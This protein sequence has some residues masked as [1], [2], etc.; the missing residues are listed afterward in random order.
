MQFD[1]VVFAGGGN[2]CWWQAGFWHALNEEYHQKPHLITAVSAGAATACLLYTRPGVDGARWALQYYEKVLKDIHKNAYWENLFTTKPVFPHCDIYKGVLEQVIA[3][4]LELLQSAP[5]IKIGVSVAPS[6][7]GARSSVAIGLLAYQLEKRF[8]KTLHPR[9]GQ[10]I[11]FTRNFYNTHDCNTANNLVDVILQSSCTPP[12]TPVM[13][14]QGQVVLDGGLVDN[15][16]IDGL[17]FAHGGRILV[18]LTRRY[19]YPDVFKRIYKNCELIYVQP[20]RPVAISS[21]DYSRQELMPITYQ[22]G[23]TDFKTYLSSD[24]FQN[25]PSFA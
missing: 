2:R 14:R 3:T 21:W 19:S 7:L 16:P 13:V 6:Y 24:I 10:R 11:G 1:Q 5:P 25:P 23:L 15:V 22:Q 8:K 9:G 12:F 18:M 4:K 17:D 20:S